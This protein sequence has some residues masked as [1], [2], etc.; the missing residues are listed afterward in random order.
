MLVL[1]V[2][3]TKFFHIVDFYVRGHACTRA[4]M[5]VYMFMLIHLISHLESVNW[6]VEV[7][8]LNPGTLL[9]ESGRSL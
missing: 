7:Y 1:V 3:C 6:A 5:H 4:C 9:A 2:I 8:V